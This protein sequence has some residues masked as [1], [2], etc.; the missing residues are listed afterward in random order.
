M[1]YLLL[2]LCALHRVVEGRRPQ[3]EEAPG[4][5]KMRSA[6]RR[7]REHALQSE[8]LQERAEDIARS[9]LIGIT[10]YTTSAKNKVASPHW[11]CCPSDWFST[12]KDE[13]R[14][15]VFLVRPFKS[16]TST[17]QMVLWSWAT[18]RSIPHPHP[19]ATPLSLKL[20]FCG[21]SEV[22]QVQNHSFGRSMS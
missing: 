16:G 17:L 11:R 3:R 7:S 15:E 6:H 5:V 8:L 19:P 10:K 12:R 20:F 4:H 14:G 13:R 18:R 22:S 2:L 21:V 1:K 9:E